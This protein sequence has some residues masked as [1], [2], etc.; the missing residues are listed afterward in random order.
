MHLRY[1]ELL[2]PTLGEL[3]TLSVREAEVLAWVARGKS[4]AAVGDTSGFRRTPSMRTSAAS[5]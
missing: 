1:C 2:M 4:N 5:T 3:P